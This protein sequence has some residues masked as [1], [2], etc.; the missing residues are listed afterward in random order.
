MSLFNLVCFL[1]AFIILVVPIGK[2]ISKLIIHEK[3]ILDG[4]FTHVD[5]LIYKTFGCKYENQ[6][7]KQYISAF[8]MSNLV[9]FILTYVILGL[10]D[11]TIT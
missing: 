5:K 6:T 9:M 11:H 10:K 3:T 1:F 7:F 8:L 2:H 4:V